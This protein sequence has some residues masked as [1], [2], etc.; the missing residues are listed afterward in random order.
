MTERWGGYGRNV[1]SNPEACGVTMLHSLED[2]EACYSFDTIILVKDNESGRLY[3]A[4]DSGCSCP[5]PF[6]YIRG[7][8]DMMEIL[9]PVQFEKFVQ[10]EDIGFSY[11]KHR[12]WPLSDVWAASRKVYDEIRK[13]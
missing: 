12:T 7:L 13:R 2:P 4:H 1:Y 11:S 5:T 8:A 6:E 3:T 9:S 10:A